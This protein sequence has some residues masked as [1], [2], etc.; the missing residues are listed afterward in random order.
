VG[1]NPAS[2]YYWGDWLND[3]ELQLASS[4]TRGI[5]ANA[6]ARMWYSSVRGE[7]IATP[8]KFT[9][10]LNCTLTEMGTFLSEAEALLFCYVLRND[11]G[12]I[13]LRNRRMYREARAK[14]SNRLR[15]E[16][17]RERRKDNNEITPPSSVFSLQSSK[18]IA[19]AD[20]SE[21]FT[22]KILNKGY[23]DDLP[24]KIIKLCKELSGDKFNPYQWVQM[25]SDGHPKALLSVLE[26][27]KKQGKLVKSKWPYAEKVLLVKNQNHNEQDAMEAHKALM[28]E[29]KEWLEGEE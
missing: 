29:M 24:K 19:K 14:E 11:D 17:Y 12:T 15:Q 16:K 2:Q 25:N 5:W 23:P 4:A 10:L 8:E 6:L 20:K 13:T 26:D 22:K 27:L 7:M 9:Q 21:H 18:I 28:Q 3:W 1:K